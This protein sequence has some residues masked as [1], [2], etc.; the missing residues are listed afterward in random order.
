MPVQVLR[1]LPLAIGFFDF[2]GNEYQIQND[3]Y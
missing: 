3:R 1:Q 2:R